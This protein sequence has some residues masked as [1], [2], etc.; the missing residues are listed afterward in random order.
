MPKPKVS[1]DKPFEEVSICKVVFAKKKL[2]TNKIIHWD[3]FLCKNPD[4]RLFRYDEMVFFSLFVYKE[5][6]AMTQRTAL[7]WAF[8]HGAP[9]RSLRALGVPLT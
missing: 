4:G 7:K 8:K 1:P 5:R 9:N 2:L 3:E 6:R